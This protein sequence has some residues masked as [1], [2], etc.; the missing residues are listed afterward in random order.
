MTRTQQ[1]MN[2]L[3][4]LTHSRFR[5]I[6]CTLALKTVGMPDVILVLLVEFVIGHVAERLPP[7]YNSFFDRETQNLP[8]RQFEI[9]SGWG[10]DIP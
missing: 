2:R 1:I 9:S 6:I 4:T 8:A 5:W 3:M 7:E 10:N